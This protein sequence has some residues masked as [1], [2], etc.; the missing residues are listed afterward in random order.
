MTTLFERLRD[1][2]SKNLLQKYGDVF[3]ITKSADPVYNPAT[4]AVVASTTYQDVNGKS[5]SMEQRF[6]GG[7]MAETAKVEIFITANSITFEPQAGMSI[8][9]P[10]DSTAPLQ[11]SN[12]QRIPESGAAV[13]YRLVAL[14]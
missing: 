10:T 9:S 7:E 14:K 6:D 5:F 1:G 13:M 3:R 12:V 2:V 8:K 11:I 4:G